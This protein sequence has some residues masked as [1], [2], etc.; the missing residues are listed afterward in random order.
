MGE[1]WKHVNWDGGEKGALEGEGKGGGARWGEVGGDWRG[2][3]GGRGHRGRSQMGG[4]G[5]GE[6]STFE[7]SK[8]THTAATS[9][10]LQK[11]K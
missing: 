2:S 9:Y 4:G 10:P 8:A 1:G 5:G 6:R 3:I 11:A 7:M